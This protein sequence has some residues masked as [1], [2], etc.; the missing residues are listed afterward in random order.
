MGL[1]AARLLE[2]VAYRRV[3]GL[4]DSRAPAGG[5]FL[6]CDGALGDGDAGR[7]PGR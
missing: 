4:G 3:H 1:T 7:S 5:S 6:G 2:P